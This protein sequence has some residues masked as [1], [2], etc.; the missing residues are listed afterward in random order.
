MA[1]Q[2][3]TVLEFRVGSLAEPDLIV[4]SVSGRER[5]SDGYAFDVE[6]LP[7]S[8]EPLDLNELAGAEALLTLRR[9]DGTERLVHGVVWTAQHH[10]VA[11][12]APH[13][14]ARVVPAL[15]RLRHVRRSRIFQSKSVPDVVKEVLDEAQVKHRFCT[16]ASYAPREYCV[17]YRESNLEFVQRLLQEE[18]IFYWF[19]HA[20]DEHVMNLA[21]SA[22]SCADLPGEP[23]VP[24]RFRAGI[25]DSTD[26][27]HL[28]RLERSQ[29]LRTGKVTLKDFDFERPTVSVLGSCKAGNDA[30]G[31]ECYEYP[32]G[33]RDAK[34]GGRASQIRLEE[35]RSGVEAF[36]GESTC[37]RFA[38]GARF[39]GLEHPE[40]CFN[41]KL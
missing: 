5:L 22:S 29:R 4:S 37:L 40:A 26:L 30:F 21:D 1:T 19:E 28:F 24:F 35:L 32:G 15:E 39:E 38:S 13:Y 17:Q 2:H 14:R 16:N 9:P 11:S 41:R 23:T 10:I 25:G 20:P 36:S 8:G 34:G 33:F 12:G 6:F 3:R 27:E 7:V 31:L 18:G